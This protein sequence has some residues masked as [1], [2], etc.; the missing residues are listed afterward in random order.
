MLTEWNSYSLSYVDLG[1][2]HISNNQKTFSSS[3]KEDSIDSFFCILWRMADCTSQ[4]KMSASFSFFFLLSLLCCCQFSV[5]VLNRIVYLNI[6]ILKETREI[7]RLVFLVCRRSRWF[8]ICRLVVSSRAHSPVAWHTWLTT[9]VLKGRRYTIAV[10]QVAT[11]GYYINQDVAA[12]RVWDALTPPLKM[13]RFDE[14]DAD[15][16]AQST[17]P[18][19][20][21][22]THTH[23]QRSNVSLFSAGERSTRLPC[24]KKEKAGGKVWCG[25]NTSAFNRVSLSDTV[26]EVEMPL[27]KSDWL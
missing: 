10:L 12:L 9:D 16:R 8:P 17:S 26:R 23:T 22:N 18:L 20:W 4:M 15:C 27:F 24:G 13:A 11:R 25:G 19:L 21:Y 14:I 1:S 5:D 7:E 3:T 6:N 2:K